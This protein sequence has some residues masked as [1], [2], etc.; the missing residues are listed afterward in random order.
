M[1]KRKE[2]NELQTSAMI[3]NTLETLQGGG[4]YPTATPEE[5]YQRK[6]ELRTQGKKGAKSD[7]YNMA[8]TPANYDYINVV[9]RIRGITKTKLVNEIVDEYREHNPELYNKAKKILAEIE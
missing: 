7:R 2:E 4:K 8:F 5:A 1:A 9:A 3:T 6:S